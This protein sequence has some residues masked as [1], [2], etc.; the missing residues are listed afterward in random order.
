MKESSN[1]SHSPKLSRRRFLAESSVAA[2]VVSVVPSH[3]LGG[4]RHVAPNDR[5][6]IA[7]I[8]CGTQGLRQLMPA[9]ESKEIRVCAVCDPNRKSD[10]YPEWGPHELNDKI[11]KF[12]ND[13]NWAKDARGGLCGR[14]VGLEV[15]NRFYARQAGEKSG[16]CRAYTDFRELLAQ[17]KDLDAVYIMTPEHLHG[18]I[19]VRAM[20][21]GKHVITHKPISN[22]LQEVRAVRD[23][24]RETGVASHLFCAAQQETT[25]TIKEW[26]QSGAIGPVREVHNWSSRPFWP[27]GMLEAPRGDVPVP[28]GF[29]WDLW[30]GP[31][32]KRPYHPAYTHAVF[33]GWYD[34]GTGAL[35]DMGHYSFHQ[36]FEILDLGSCRSVEAR[37]SQ[38]WKIENYTWHKQINRVSYPEASLIT[39]E[40]PEAGSRP[41]VTLHWYDGGL[42]PPVIK[43]LERDGEEMPEEGMLFVGDSGKIL[44]E[45]TAEKPRLIPKARM[46]SFTPPPKT[47]PRPIG[48]LEQFVRACKGGLAS[49]ASFEKAYPFAETI[50]LGTIAQRVEKKLGW[51]AAKFEF[52][53]SP[54]ANALKTRQNRPGWEI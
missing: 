6:N 20:R 4:A 23:T 16:P 46:Q 18:V 35:G 44:A 38:F 43:E 11:R 54:E 31:A 28:D 52:T 1:S 32:A 3:V 42:R 26:I 9:L 2:A 7:H 48:E 15:V 51:D 10:D 17:E 36:I 14:E 22:V 5:I 37:R 27:Q 19:A 25:P 33:R 13:P 50:L 40:F 29:L 21:Q 12:L 30:L 45:F 8:G 39:W 41:E 47:L 24:A 53:N 34:F 49:D